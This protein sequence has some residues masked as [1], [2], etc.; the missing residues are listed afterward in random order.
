MMRVA[1]INLGGLGNG[2]SRSSIPATS[3]HV[4]S[5]SLFV[6][7][8]HHQACCDLAND[9][10]FDS[11]SYCSCQLHQIPNIVAC[12]L[13]PT[14]CIEVVAQDFNIIQEAGYMEHN[15]RKVLS[16]IQVGFLQVHIDA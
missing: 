5:P 4:L 3:Y 16:L 12:R 10:L 6:Q 11:W 15:R 14:C 7:Q 9:G 8:Q 2:L 13:I 1:K